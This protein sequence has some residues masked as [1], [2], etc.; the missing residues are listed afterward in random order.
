MGQAAAGASP[1]GGGSGGYRLPLVLVLVL[2]DQH[3]AQLPPPD[4]HE[5]I[6]ADARNKL[7]FNPSPR[8]ARNL[9]RPVAPKLSAHDLSHL[10]AYTA[11]IRLIIA[12]TEVHAGRRAGRPVK[13]RGGSGV[14]WGVALR[15]EPP[16]TIGRAGQR[17]AE[18]SDG[19]ADSK[20]DW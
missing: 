13:P 19:W 7:L 10:G 20:G 12:G 11:A 16:T 1:P 9:E 14:G 5:G 6:S 17:P 8:N 18:G 15:S 4:V 2:V 3:P